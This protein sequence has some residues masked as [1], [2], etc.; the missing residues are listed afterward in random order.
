[1]YKKILFML[2]IVITCK[3]GICQYFTNIN[4]TNFYEIKNRFV[5]AIQNDSIED[6]G[7][8]RSILRWENFWEKRLYSSGN[9]KIATEA[10]RNYAFEFAQS[11]LSSSLNN[12]NWISLGPSNNNL[13]NGVGRVLTVAID[14]NNSNTIYAGAWNGGVW[15][16]PRY[17]RVRNACNRNKYT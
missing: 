4:D 3:S 7:P 6:D 14:P 12:S 9:F 8:S 1:M 11:S 5:E 13:T 16:S 10:M 15:K 2:F 17:A